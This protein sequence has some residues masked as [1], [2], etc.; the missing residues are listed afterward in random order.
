MEFAVDEQGENYGDQERKNDG[1]ST[2]SGQ[3]SA[4][5]MSRIRRSGNQSAP[6]RRVPNQ[7]RGNKTHDQRPEKGPEVEECQVSPPSPQISAAADHPCWKL[8]L[9]QI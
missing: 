7:L 2:E 5:Q 9:G 4:M 8:A 6:N 3:R 1:D